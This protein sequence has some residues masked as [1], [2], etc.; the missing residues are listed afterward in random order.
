[1]GLHYPLFI[2]LN[3]FLKDTPD[4]EKRIGIYTCC[5]TENME[6]LTEMISHI[7]EG[8]VDLET[9]GCIPYFL[10]LR[11]GKPMRGFSGVTG[12]EIT[13]FMS[14]NLPKIKIPKENDPAQ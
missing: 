13:E 7:H 11:N 12:P 9:N 8:V 3:Q 5:I 10:F 4:C 6:R 14:D 1:M 2:S